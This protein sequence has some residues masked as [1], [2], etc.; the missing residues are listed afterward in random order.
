MD[1]VR[2]TSRENR[3]SDCPYNNA[4][5]I[6]SCTHNEDAG[7][8]CESIS[9]MN[10]FPIML[11]VQVLNA[12]KTVSGFVVVSHPGKGELKSVLEGHGGQCVMMVGVE[13]MLLLLAGS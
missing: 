9:M 8:R 13:M 10:C 7:V 4:N 5:A 11:I 3:L 12:L 2:C 1:N 6:R